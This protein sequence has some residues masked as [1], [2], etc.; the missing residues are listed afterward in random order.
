MHLGYSWPAWQSLM[1][2]CDDDWLVLLTQTLRHCRLLVRN[3]VS[4]ILAVLENLTWDSLN[5]NPEVGTWSLGYTGPS[6]VAWI[7]LSWSKAISI[8]EWLGST[9]VLISSGRIKPCLVLIEQW[10]LCID[11]LTVG[12]LIFLGWGFFHYILAHTR[13][14]EIDW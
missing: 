14:G 8:C 1:H 5:I 10:Y 4:H 9:V 11:Y 12:M 6:N 2:K 7:C 13:C 3:E